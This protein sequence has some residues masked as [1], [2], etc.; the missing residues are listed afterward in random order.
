[1]NNLTRESAPRCQQRE[2]SLAVTEGVLG[3][4]LLCLKQTHLP[5][6]DS[7]TQ[8]HTAMITV[9]DYCKDNCKFDRLPLSDT[10]QKAPVLP[11]ICMLTHSMSKNDQHHIYF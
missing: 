4:H 11:Q 3:P 2:E 6:G 8:M 7:I 5:V 1:M 9:N 10:V